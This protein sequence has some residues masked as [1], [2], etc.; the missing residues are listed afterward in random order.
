M[1]SPPDNQNIHFLSNKFEVKTNCKLIIARGAPKTLLS[2]Y[3]SAEQIF[4][5]FHKEKV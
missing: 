4:R 2:A 3:L 5:H 1:T